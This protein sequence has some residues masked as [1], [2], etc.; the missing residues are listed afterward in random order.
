MPNTLLL[1]VLATGT[2]HRPKSGGR[3]PEL[4]VGESSA[5]PKTAAR[6]GSNAIGFQSPREFKEQ[7]KPAPGE[8]L[9]GSNSKP[10]GGATQRRGSAWEVDLKTFG[11]GPS[12]R[13][14][15]VFTQVTNRRRKL[16]A[17]VDLAFPFECLE[18]C[19]FVLAGCVNVS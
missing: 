7:S 8:S 9:R 12:A 5:R 18:G 4:T 1:A 11:G 15:R 19:T 2:L 16:Q 17:S 13:R 14:D 6:F 10:A 3:A